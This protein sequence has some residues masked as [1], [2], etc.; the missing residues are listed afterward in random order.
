MGSQ[1]QNQYQD[2]TLT[3]PEQAP[4]LLCWEQI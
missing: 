3:I 2:A 4:Q 1:D